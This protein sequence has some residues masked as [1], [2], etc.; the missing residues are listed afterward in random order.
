MMARAAGAVVRAGI[1]DLLRRRDPV[2]LAFLMA[3]FLTGVLAVRMVGI[4]NAATGTFL[5]NL[6]LTL[7][8]GASHVLVALMAARQ[9]AEELEQRTL[10]LLLARPVNRTL[11]LVSKWAAVAL[12]GVASFLTLG[13]LAWLLV[14]RLEAYHAGMFAQTAAAGAVSLGLVAALGLAGSLVLP[15]AVNLLVVLGLVFGA[16]TM[17]RL[18]RS[19]A[20]SG[21]GGGLT[22]LLLAYVPDVSR[23]NLVVRY[24]DGLPPLAAGELAGLLIYGGLFTAALLSLAAIRFRRMPL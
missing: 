22:A 21:P 6:G 14:P 4:G 23:L 10:L 8:L 18:L 20:G 16:G 2:V 1:L 15:R 9:M 11:I 5:L 13:L 3:V 24:T 12:A 19:G 7:S 17:I